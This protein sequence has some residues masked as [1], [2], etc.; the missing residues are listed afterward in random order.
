M[1]QLN[2]FELHNSISRKKQLRINVF[3]KILS[4]CHI[5]IKNAATKELYT[6]I[7]EVPEYVVG[8]PLFNIND[9]IDYLMNQ[10][11]DN[12]FKVELI[13]PKSLVIDWSPI[14]SDNK[15]SSSY[16]DTYMIDHYIPYK[17]HK[18]KFILNVD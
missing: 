12:G 3:E 2:I 14:T 13:F 8:L 11:K 5:K 16:E 7:Y 10:L 1:K 18:G 17:N 9:C 15:A 4:K 6:C